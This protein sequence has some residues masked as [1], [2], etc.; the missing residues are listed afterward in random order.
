MA[1]GLKFRI[2]KVE[3]WHYLCSENKGADQRE[4]DL[5]L[6]FRISSLQC[7][8]V[9]SIIAQN[10][11][12]M[13][14]K[15]LVSI[16]LTSYLSETLESYNRVKICPYNVNNLVLMK[17]W[18]QYGIYGHFFNFHIEHYAL[19]FAFY[20]Q[21]YSVLSLSTTHNSIYGVNLYNVL[22]KMITWA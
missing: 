10:L 20:V 19:K 1:R 2:K 16:F 22:T 15:N 17:V 21:C 4:A 8:S 5:R 11:R 7:Y 12:K 3:G 14:L 18:Q 13:K 9:L 6:C